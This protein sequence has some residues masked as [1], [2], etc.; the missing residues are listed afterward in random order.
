MSSDEDSSRKVNLE[1]KHETLSGILPAWWAET[2][3][4]T[5][6]W[7]LERGLK[8]SLVAALLA[9]EDTDSKKKTS[10]AG[11]LYF[12]RDTKREAVRSLCSRTRESTERVSHVAHRTPKKN[13]RI[14]LRE[15]NNWLDPSG[16][17]CSRRP[18]E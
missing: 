5:E 16:R 9:Q 13:S 1:G 6:I 15:A 18:A 2:K 12:E 3:L 4:L 11:A 17:N 7:A 14:D 8:S 10:L